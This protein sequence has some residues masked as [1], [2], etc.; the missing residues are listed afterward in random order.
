MS[1]RQRIVAAFTVGMVFA[2]TPLFAPAYA[3]DSEAAVGVGGLTL[4][5]SKDISLDYEDLYISAEEVRIN[6]RFTNH[7]K[8]D[9]DTLIS[10]PLPVTYESNDG[11]PVVFD[12]KALA[13]ETTVEGQKAQ[14]T[15]VDVAMVGDRNVD[16]ALKQRGWDPTLGT[17]PE[18]HRTFDK[19]SKADI[20]AAVREGLLKRNGDEVAVNW[21]V[22]RHVTRHQKFP[23]GK[24][25]AV[26]HRYEPM[27][28]GSIGGG[29]NPD[30]REAEDGS[31]AFYRKDYCTDDNFLRGFD[32]KYARMRKANPETIAYTETWLAYVLSSGA[33]WKGPIK[34]FRLVVDKSAPDSLVSFC[35]DG[36]KKISPTQFEVRKKNFEPQTDLNILIVNWVHGD[37]G[38]DE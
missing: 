10:F 16:V 32:Q 26:R 20:D 2:A 22:Q 24:T 25:I 29:L 6:Y 21:V 17:D 31:G 30:Y 15:V 18:D 14:L 38:T 7:S 19:L 27:I 23:A 11:L 5:N 13:F 35:M 34:D 28:G 3:N 8:R 4:V 33:N 37:S 1:M 12:P 9:I 36:V